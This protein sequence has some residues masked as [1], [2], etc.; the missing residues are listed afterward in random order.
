MNRTHQQKL[1]R[2]SIVVL[3]LALIAVVFSVNHLSPKASADAAPEPVSY[4]QIY[5]AKGT[6]TRAQIKLINPTADKKCGGDLNAG[7]QYTKTIKL[8]ATRPHKVICEAV[9]GGP[10][11]EVKF[12]KG[13]KTGSTSDYITVPGITTVDVD[14]SNSIPYKSCMVINPTAVTKTQML[15]TNC[16]IVSETIPQ[17]P[18]TLN[19]YLRSNG[20]NLSASS[21][22]T[23][24][25]RLVDSSPWDYDGNSANLNK[26]KFISRSFCTGT[27]SVWYQRTGAGIT[28]AEQGPFIK[29]LKYAKPTLTT[30]YGHCEVK[31]SR[32]RAQI[33]KKATY[34]M[35]ATF[36]SNT[37]LGASNQATVT[38]T[39]K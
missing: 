27:V 30:P 1:I 20:V 12:L 7:N 29:K 17:D 24:H 14:Y 3:S 19:I 37:Y 21:A 33:A 16:T 36:G 8:Y 6:Y 23:G 28:E 2:S 34:N 10:L 22:P 4:M 31:L 15:P 18:S 38:F 9:G 13:R 39:T 26:Y 35:R 5:S 11:Y 32:D 25:I